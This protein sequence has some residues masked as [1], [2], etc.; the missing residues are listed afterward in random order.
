MFFFKSPLMLNLPNR[1]H[2][3]Q[4][5]LN[6]SYP[7]EPKSSQSNRGYNHLCPTLWQ[8][9][10]TSTAWSVEQLLR[11]SCYHFPRLV[12]L[13]D[14][15]A[16]RNPDDSKRCKEREHILDCRVDSQN[17]RV[18]VCHHC[19]VLLRTARRD[20]V[21]PE[22]LRTV[23]SD[24]HCPH[25]AHTQWCHLCRKIPFTAF[26]QTQQSTA[27]Q[28]K[29]NPFTSSNSRSHEHAYACSML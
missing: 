15:A 23:N 19:A 20:D 10:R 24:A 2:F 8:T 17:S 26:L 12:C 3:Q 22:Q 6:E 13:V 1:A 18:D 14:D 7:N 11:W 28:S 4:N 29:A 25:T 21:C 16:V 27:K 9:D 5:L